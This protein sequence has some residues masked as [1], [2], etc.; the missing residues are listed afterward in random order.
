MELKCYYIKQNLNFMNRWFDHVT[1]AWLY[2]L[3]H[4]I[5]LRLQKH[6]RYDRYLDNMCLALKGSQS[7]LF[8]NVHI[9]HKVI[10]LNGSFLFTLVKLKD[11]PDA[12]D[13]LSEASGHSSR[14]HQPNDLNGKVRST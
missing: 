5:L 7:Q 12:S 14:E 13:S 1:Q 3:I 6:L 9:P 4:L 2:I 8:F 10:V 11:L